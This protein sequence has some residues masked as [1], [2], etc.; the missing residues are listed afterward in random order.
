MAV[1][2]GLGKTDASLE[3]FGIHTMLVVSSSGFLLVLVRSG[4]S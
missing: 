4:G 1:S 3:C 2:G